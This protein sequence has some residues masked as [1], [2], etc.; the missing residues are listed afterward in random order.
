MMKIEYTFE[1]EPTGN[2][3]YATYELEQ[4]ESRPLKELTV[5]GTEEYKIVSR[6]ICLEHGK[7]KIILQ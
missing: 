1:H 4:I 5:L 6:I 7:G 3:H 2:L